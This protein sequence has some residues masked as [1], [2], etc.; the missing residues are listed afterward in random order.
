M[1]HT[2]TLPAF[3]SESLFHKLEKG[4]TPSPLTFLQTG[5]ASGLQREKKGDGTLM[6]DGR[7]KARAA[8]CSPVVSQPILTITL[9][10]G[11]L[12][13]AMGRA[14]VLA[15]FTQTMSQQCPNPQCLLRLEGFVLWLLIPAHGCSCFIP[16]STGQTSGNSVV[17][18][19]HI[20]SMC[21]LMPSTLC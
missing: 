6:K 8:G 16:A 10:K 21:I 18:F 5:L 12:G 17:S 2:Q 4:A 14:P 7:I 11:A 13:L 20:Y 15:A 1:Q 3:P 9:R 19:R